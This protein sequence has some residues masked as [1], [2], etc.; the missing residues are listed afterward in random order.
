MTD[1]RRRK[2]CRTANRRLAQWR[3]KWLME[4]STWHQLLWTVE[5]FELRKPPERGAR[6]RC[7][8]FEKKHRNQ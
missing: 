8:Q 3:V 2:E 6:N 7:P 5:S 1:H 4:H